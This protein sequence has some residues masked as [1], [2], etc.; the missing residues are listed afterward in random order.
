MNIYCFRIKIDF[1]LEIFIF[2][3]MVLFFILVFVKWVFSSLGKDFDIK[4]PCTEKVK[5]NMEEI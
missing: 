5:V 2:Q 3:N 1:I 4:K